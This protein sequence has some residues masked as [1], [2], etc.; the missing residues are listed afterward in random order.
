GR[1][2]QTRIV[3]MAEEQTDGAVDEAMEPQPGLVALSRVI[4]RVAVSAGLGAALWIMDLKVYGDSG[5]LPDIVASP[6]FGAWIG[7]AAGLVWGPIIELMAPR[8]T[9]QQR[10]GVL[11]GSMLMM[12]V[13]TGIIWGIPPVRD[14]WGLRMLVVASL[15]AAVVEGV[16][17]AICTRGAEPPTEETPDEEPPTEETPPD[18]PASEEPPADEPS[19]EPAVDA[20]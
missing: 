9:E 8:A 10:W 1:D 4:I 17:L 16:A 6:I 14:W 7:A 3:A 13:A 20:S 12:C 2:C 18:E 5:P 11:A 19:A 15:A